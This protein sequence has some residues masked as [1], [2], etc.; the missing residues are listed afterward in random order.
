M[1]ILFMGTPEFAVPCLEQMAKEGHEICGVFTQP[2]KRSGRGMTLRKPAVKIAAE[3]L[4]ISVH[5]PEG[6]KNDGV[7]DTIRALAPEA[8][9]VTAYGRILPEAVLNIPPLGC[10]NVHAS[11][12]PAYRG[13]APMQWAVINGEK[14]TGITTMYMAKGLD[15]GDMILKEE[16]PIGDNETFGE[17][18]DR[19]QEIGARLLLRTL[20]LIAKGEAPRTAQGNEGATYAPM[21]D[22]AVSM[23]DFR[24]TAQQVHN[25]VRGLSPFPGAASALNGMP[26]KIYETKL[27]DIVSD[28]PPG[29]I[30]RSDEG[31]GVYCG[32]GRQ[33]II[34]QIQQKSGKKMSATDYLNGHKNAASGSFQCF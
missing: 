30:A 27:T 33:I 28:C 17:L 22:N 14:V 5:Q 24:K 34:T 21:I 31:I 9:V 6:L 8:I 13:A 19:L 4:G 26:V 12:L 32:D 15:T 23:I 18:Y 20:D 2:D 10:I 1:R 25:L 7:I 11:L 29:T 16:T 3:S